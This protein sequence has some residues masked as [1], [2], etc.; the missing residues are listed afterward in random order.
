MLERLA[1]IEAR[2]E[3][4]T[5]LLSDPEVVSD[6]RQ[7]EELGRE[8]A[9]LETVVTLYREYRDALAALDDAKALARD[10]DEE[11]RALGREEEE[12]LT[13]EVDRLD[14]EL[15]V[16]LLPRDPA[17]DKDVIVEIRGGT[18]G[19]EAA[20]FA[21]DLYRMYQRYAERHRWKTEVLN[22][23]GASAGGYKEIVFEVHGQGAYSRLKYESGVHRV[24]RV[25]ETEAQG[26]IHT[27]TATVAV[28]PEVDDLEVDIDWGQVRIDIFH[29]GGAGGQN[30]NKVATAVR[31]T[32]EP[33][34]IVVTC[35]DERS[36]AK[37][38]AKAE[39]VLRARLYELERAAAAAEQAGARRAQVG[40]G[41]RSEKIRTYNFPQDRVTDHR[42]NM[43]VHGMP[44]ILDGDID[45][46][47]DAVA[48]DE[49]A[50][51]LQ[52]VS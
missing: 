1:E 49:Q 35:Q 25:P 21:S 27:S 4:V 11:L 38:R 7:L 19:E 42:V 17:D 9:H 13:T 37:N 43:T 18:G 26:R 44:R 5:R 15:K 2:Y 32:H 6:H 39:A 33:T 40:T 12:R 46:L 8:R 14:N 16:A 30:V 52:A 41:E 28:L 34:G 51:L 50:Q 20:L 31:M 29:S 3:E 36:Q 48:V 45:P 22:T 23:S 10:P 24:Q 47:I